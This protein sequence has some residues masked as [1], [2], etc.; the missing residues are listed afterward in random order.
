[1]RVS[2]MDRWTDHCGYFFQQDPAAEC[3][4]LHPSNRLNPHIDFLL[5]RPN[6]VY[7]Y[8]K[9]CT[10]GASDYKLPLTLC[11]RN[12]FIM[13]IHREEDLENRKILSWYCDVLLSVALYPA[14]NRIAVT[15]GHSIVWGEKSGTDMWCA[16]LDFPYPIPQPG[17]FRCRLGPVKE[18]NCLQVI[19]LTKRETEQ[20]MQKGPEGFYDVL[21]PGNAPAH[22]LCERYRS[23]R[24]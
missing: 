20:L 3:I 10:M 14:E 9:L 2:E 7:P 1:M 19:L 16:Y 13:F 6:S 4:V 22:F 8:W 23:P 24:F 12:E 21:C 15:F 11:H 5:F 18:T 17:F